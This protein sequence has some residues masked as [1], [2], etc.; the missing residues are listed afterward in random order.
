MSAGHCGQG[1][2]VILAVCQ[3]YFE[4]DYCIYTVLG[5]SECFTWRI[6]LYLEMLCVVGRMG[7][8]RVGGGGDVLGGRLFGAA[9]L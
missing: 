2:N 7:F 4:T 6:G 3:P 8:G 9:G 5:P 1:H